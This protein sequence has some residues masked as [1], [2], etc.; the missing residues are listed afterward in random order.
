MNSESSIF[1]DLNII[2]DVLQNREPFFDTSAQLLMLVE[3]KKV[4]GYIAAHSVTI[5]FYLIKNG[6]SS[7]DARAIITSLLQF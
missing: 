2:L 1:I 7:A 3:T 6:K 4:S 5:L